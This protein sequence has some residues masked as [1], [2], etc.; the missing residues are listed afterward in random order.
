MGKNTAAE[1]ELKFFLLKG[2]L[3]VATVRKRA[4]GY[5]RVS[6]ESQME[7]TSI[8]LQR[9]KIINYCELYDF[10][11]AEL[12]VD[13]GKS[14]SSI[15]AREEYK[16]MTEFVS[17]YENHIDVVITL[18]AD[19]MHR[20]LKN[21]LVMIEDI[22][23]PA[24]VAFISITENFDTSTSQGMLLLQMLGSFAEFERT[25]INERTKSGRVAKAKNT[26]Y[27]GGEPAYGLKVIGGKLVIDSDKAEIVKE[28]FQM[29][30]DRKSTESIAKYLNKAGIPTKKQ[31]NHWS[32]QTVGY[33]LHNPIY[34]GTYTYHGKT[35]KN[36][37]VY[38]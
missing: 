38:F 28:I 25:V 6:T 30:A 18:K 29:S 15:E 16:R 4:V 36:R 23:Q 2:G 3:N 1:K 17:A 19:R 21:L 20:K 34:K 8:D 11:L 5:A 37:I 12:F 10:E 13:S 26:S 27:A 9:E 24:N 32:R 31:S 14:G 22:L 33:I 35:E 7:N